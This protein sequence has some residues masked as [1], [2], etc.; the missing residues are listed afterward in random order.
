VNTSCIGAHRR[1]AAALLVGMAVLAGGIVGCGGSSTSSDGGSS[2]S[3]ATS[4]ESGS[5]TSTETAAATKPLRYGIPVSS[6]ESGVSNPAEIQATDGP[7]LS[8]AYASLTHVE[9]DGKIA[10]GLATKWK[11]LGDEQKVFELTLRKGVKFSDG[12]PLDAEAVVGWL[13]YYKDSENIYSELLGKNPKFEA[14][15]DSTVKIT[16][17]EPLPGLPFLFSEANVNWGFVASPKA[18]A[19][20]KLMKNATYGAGPYMLDA[21]KSVPGDHYVYVPNPNYYDPSNVKFSEIEMKAFADSSTALQ[22]QQAGQIDVNWTLEAS[23]APAAE[24]SGLEIVSA[25]FAVYYLALNSQGPK[26]LKD[27]R[28][29]QALNYAVDREAIATALFNKYGVASSQFTI[30]P[31]A[32]PEMED[33]YAYDPDK[34]R[35][36]LAEAGYEDGFPFQIDIQTEPTPTKAAQLVADNLEAVGI[37]AK[38]ESFPT[39]GAY[40]ARAL[41]LKDDSA[42]FAG[43]VGVPTPI[44]YPSYIAPGSELGAA[45]PKDPEVDKLYHEGLE[46][47]DPAKYWKPMWAITVE[48]AW[49][50][51]MAALSNLEYVSDSVQGVEMSKT[52]PYSYPTEWS[53]K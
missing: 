10:P 29:R 50:L 31:D 23:T 19:D 44:E 12:T 21:G 51:P 37:E 8:I 38:I 53:F 18:V 49:F 13:Q 17:E 7:V 32:N 11:Y 39:R 41:P 24:S 4:T 52:R 26:P 35:E 5:T 1:R 43:D 3:P 2:S 34:A 36:L 48:D 45:D 40:L 9:P 25:P 15:D 30:P 14:V 46:S 42:I 27:V 16:M 6:V 47:T 28:V 22:A 20:P 33:F